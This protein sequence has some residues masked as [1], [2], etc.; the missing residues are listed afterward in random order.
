[1]ECDNCE[2]ESVSTYDDSSMKGLDDK[3]YWE[4]NGTGFATMSTVLIIKESRMNILI[5]RG[6]EIARG[7]MC[8][9][10][11]ENLLELLVGDPPKARYH[12]SYLHSSQPYFACRTTLTTT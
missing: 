7:D 10:A 3:P 1:M 11:P 6:Q 9:K 2:L 12:F 4:S 8:R 5:G